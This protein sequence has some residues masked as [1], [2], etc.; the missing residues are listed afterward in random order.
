MMAAAEEILF[1]FGKKLTGLNYMT[2]KQKKGMRTWDFTQQETKV[3]GPQNA[4]FFSRLF[5]TLSALI[6]YP[7][8]V[9]LDEKLIMGFPTLK[10]LDQINDKNKIV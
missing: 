1:S 7:L 10:S 6:I 2:S 8:V 4:F 9:S 3:F 5:K